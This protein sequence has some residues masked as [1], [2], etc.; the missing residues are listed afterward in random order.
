MLIGKFRD[1]QKLRGRKFGVLIPMLV[2]VAVSGGLLLGAHLIA[3]S[4]K[5][6]LSKRPG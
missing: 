4:Q 5:A 6:D 3:P 1:P 2:I